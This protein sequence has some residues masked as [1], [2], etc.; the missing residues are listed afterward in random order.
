MLKIVLAVSA[1]FLSPITYSSVEHAPTQKVL[2]EAQDYLTVDP[3]YTLKL[4]GQVSNI[5]SL[6]PALFV[7]LHIIA[8]RAYVPTNQLDNMLN[9]LDALFSH[10]DEPYFID[11]ATAVL[12][13]LGIWLR[14]N[15][16]LE[17]SQVSLECA[18][19]LAHT[20]KQ[21]FTLTNSLALVSRQLNEYEKAQD[22]YSR[23]L[24][25]AEQNE[26]TSLFAMI[27]NNL[28]AIDLDLGRI[29]NAE[30]HFR[31]SLEKYQSVDKRSGIIS[32]GI[33][34]LFAFILQ[35]QIIN[36]ERLYEPT[37]N[38][39]TAFPNDS[40]KALLFWL[41]TRFD[42]LEGKY[43]TP[44]IEHRLKVAYSQLEDDKI[45][46]LVYENLASKL[47]IDVEKP[48][49]RTPQSFNSPWFKEVQ[50]CKW[51]TLIAE[52]QHSPTN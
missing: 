21:R 31:I 44:S 51:K 36:F 37:S 27:H 9:S 10:S 41:K 5:E 48:P 33:N 43:L 22:L 40:K 14:R 42:Q 23:L 28:G 46:K 8:L 3:S 52:Y 29:K 15:R 25:L 2:D 4:L 1:L 11:N 13:G 39:T 34:L 50:D 24:S 16:Y 45:R 47:G 19:E 49:A 20:D 32:A 12:S 26:Q 17:D 35:E 30:Q 38:L 18:Y 7:R 6:P